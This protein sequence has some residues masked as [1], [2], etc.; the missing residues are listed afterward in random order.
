MLW[1]IWTCQIIN[2]LRINGVVL[3]RKT[4]LG[5]GVLVWMGDCLAIGSGPINDY[6]AIDQIKIYELKDAEIIGNIYEYAHL[7][8]GHQPTE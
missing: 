4:K 7:I 6:S 3:S 1:L 8:M 5:I 2:P